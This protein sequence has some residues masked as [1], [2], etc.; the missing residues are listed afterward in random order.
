MPLRLPP[1]LLLGLALSLTAASTASAAQFET[2]G[3]AS[4][5]CITTIRGP[6]AQGDLERLQAHLA[7]LQTNGPTVIN[8]IDMS[9]LQD[10]DSFYAVPVQEKR[11]CL[12][13]PG[14]SLAEV[15]KI[16]DYL[17][18]EGP[19]G[20]YIWRNTLGTAVPAGA[21]CESACAILFLAGRR[22]TRSEEGLLPDRVLHSRGK[23][24]FHAISLDLPE[25]SYSHSQVSQAF[26]L[27]VKS[28]G[29]VAD[30][31][32]DLEMR[33]SLLRLMLATPPDQM[34]YVETLAQAAQ[35]NIQLAGTPSLTEPGPANVLTACSKQVRYFV[36][37]DT[38]MRRSQEQQQL[39]PA[40]AFSE[41]LREG[42]NHWHFPVIGD[43]FST[44]EWD[45]ARDWLSF[46]SEN[47]AEHG[48]F[49]C[50]GS[51]ST[52]WGYQFENLNDY[53]RSLRAQAVWGFPG[54]MTL[55]ELAAHE[56]A[57]LAAQDPL[58][59][60]QRD[61]AARCRVF[62]GGNM[63]D[64]EPCHLTA[65]KRLTAGLSPEIVL[66]FLWPSGA[67]TV[68]TQQFDDWR[69]NGARGE[70]PNYDGL[71]EELREAEGSCLRNS[72]SGN[73]FCYTVTGS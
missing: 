70:R 3:D 60:R 48:E 4:L 23:L 51:Y 32:G 57:K 25:G 29:A 10:P 20:E 38:G 58:Y 37:E 40:V 73:L 72:G 33:L 55:A 6:I 50:Q 69:I 54:A 17:R 63:I 66:T 45:N 44:Y 64:D 27:A 67:Q 53:T 34:S 65:V 7:D 21:R 36:Q 14:G 56:G 8:G 52:V 59:S 47:D 49:Q 43:L 18:Q 2:G 13:S 26:T 41:W 71:P 12:D 28:M 35:W 22:D 62:S 15:I 5:G 16:V 9:P 46:Y 24:G 68:I 61:V 11:L 42:E 1:A 31:M 39:D 19:Y 30:R